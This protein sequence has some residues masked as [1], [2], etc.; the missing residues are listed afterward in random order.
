MVIQFGKCLIC[1]GFIRNNGEVRYLLRNH[2]RETHQDIYLSF[3]QKENEIQSKISALKREIQQLRGE[4][5]SGISQDEFEKL[6]HPIK[7]LFVQ[8]R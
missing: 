5:Y 6:K 8:T 1:D 2:I 3:N 4:Y 7:F